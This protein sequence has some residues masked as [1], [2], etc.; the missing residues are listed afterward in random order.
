MPSS[1]GRKRLIYYIQ[2][3]IQ[4]CIKSVIQDYT[5]SVTQDYIKSVIN[6]GHYSHENCA[7]RGRSAV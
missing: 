2:G 5:L 7:S 3:V 1:T 6:K 4:D